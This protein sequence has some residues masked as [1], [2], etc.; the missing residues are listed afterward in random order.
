MSLGNATASSNQHFVLDFYI[1]IEHLAAQTARHQ[2]HG[3][4][5]IGNLEIVIIKEHPD[6]L[7]GIIPKRAQQDGRRNFAA[8]V[9][10]YKHTIFGIKLE[11]E[12]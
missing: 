6:D 1:K 5:F 11:I 12:P 4:A 7:L 3:D 10:S 2:F 8:A 9:N